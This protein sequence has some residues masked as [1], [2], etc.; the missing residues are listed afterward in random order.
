[1]VVRRDKGGEQCKVHTERVL[2][3]GPT[4]SNLLPKL[5]RGGLCEG[6]ELHTNQYSPLEPSLIQL[7]Q[8]RVL[9][10]Y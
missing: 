1:M 10:H 8:Y 7:I 9:Q 3:H 2:G 6:G 5:I 4:S